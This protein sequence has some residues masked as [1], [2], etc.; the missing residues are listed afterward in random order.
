MYSIKPN[1]STA[2]IVSKR[3]LKV[4]NLS[5]KV[6]LI[7][8]LEKSPHIKKKI[9]AKKYGIPP[10]TLSTILKNKTIILERY[11]S[12]VNPKCKRLKACGFPQI[13][14]ALISWCQSYRME[15]GNIPIS[16]IML[17]EKAMD[18][19]KEMGAEEFKAS[20]G[21]L[22]KFK[23]RYKIVLK[24]LNGDAV[25][26]DSQTSKEETLVQI[27]KDYDADNI[28]SIDESVLFYKCSQNKMESEDESVLEYKLNQNKLT[29]VVGANAS[30]T[31]KLPLVVI[32]KA[33]IQY[34]SEDVES[35]RVEYYMNKMVWMTCDLFER[36]I[37]KL[38][39]M[40]HSKER[41]ILLLVGN[42]RAHFEVPD[43][44]AIKLESLPKIPSAMLQPPDKSIV[45]R[46]KHVYHEHLERMSIGSNENSFSDNID[47]LQAIRIL[48]KKWDN[49]ISQNIIIN[50]FDIQGLS[51]KQISN[52]DNIFNDDSSGSLNI[53]SLNCG[54][55]SIVV[56][57]DISNVNNVGTVKIRNN[58]SAK[59][60]SALV[61]SP[62]DID[63]TIAIATIECYLKSRSSINEELLHHLQK[64]SDFVSPQK[65]KL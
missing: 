31:E 9:L 4:L 32:G 27:L 54:G 17:R 13:E 46:L 1:F 59:D 12:N 18:F 14:S 63:V 61:E 8:E 43:L 37:R 50:S 24:S 57:R 40:F 47:V 19:A 11:A 48:S 36:Y 7:L 42:C 45:K 23:A 56:T 65:R 25:E 60:I 52:N 26:E 51:A 20:S 2:K 58:E 15:C 33:K 64:I 38:D 34:S 30:G 21:W 49:D 3:K 62:I 29:I 39:H 41:K 28:F 44:K 6:N 22:E 10:N 5:D 53:S 35:I 55:E 16:G